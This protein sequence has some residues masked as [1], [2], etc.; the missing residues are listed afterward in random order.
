M[1]DS[2]S[3][4]D[5]VVVKQLHDAWLRDVTESMKPV[6]DMPAS[7]L[8]K[9]FGLSPF[10]VSGA[11]CFAQA[12]TPL[13]KRRLLAALVDK[14]LDAALDWDKW[15]SENPDEFDCWPPT[16]QS[17]MEQTQSR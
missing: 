16:F 7:S 12:L 14:L 6:W 8:R 9:H 13:E 11:A 10:I 2:L 3:P 5:G 1:A 4:L 15:R 17:M